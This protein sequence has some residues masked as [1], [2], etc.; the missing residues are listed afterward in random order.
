MERDRGQLTERI[1][2]LKEQLAKSEQEPRREK[3][4]QLTALLTDQRSA[5]ERTR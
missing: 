5:E 4:R 3:D 1:A 2:D